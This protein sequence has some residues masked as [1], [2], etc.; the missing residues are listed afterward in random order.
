MSLEKPIKPSPEI[1]FQ[2]EKLS[3]TI[4]ECS[5]I[6]TLRN[7]AM[8]LLR[9]HEKKS[10]IAHWATIKGAEAEC[11]ALI[12]E[13]AHEA[14]LNKTYEIIRSDGQSDEMTNKSFSSYE[15]A[16]TVLERYYADLCGADEDER[17]YYDIVESKS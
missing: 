17:E 16:H 11:R 6:E 1:Q 15:E 4:Q 3:R 13:S 5:N 2:T 9:L 14:K 10:A 8:E 12:A 7:I